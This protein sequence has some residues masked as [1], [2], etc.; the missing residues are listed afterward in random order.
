MGEQKM[1]EDEAVAALTARYSATTLESDPE[2]TD[3]MIRD[4]MERGIDWLDGKGR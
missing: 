3:E 2:W 4:V 1:T